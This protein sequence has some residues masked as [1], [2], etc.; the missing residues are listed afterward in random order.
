MKDGQLFDREK[1]KVPDPSKGVKAIR[2]RA[3]RAFG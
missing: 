3:V 1:W 2:T